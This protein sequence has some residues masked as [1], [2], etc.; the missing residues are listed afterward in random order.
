M[1]LLYIYL[2]PPRL[3]RATDSG[4][5]W[6]TN[7]GYAVMLPSPAVCYR[8]LPFCLYILVWFV[9]SS[10]EVVCATICMRT[11]YVYIRISYSTA[12]RAPKHGSQRQR[13][14]NGTGEG[15]Q[16]QNGPQSCCCK[17]CKNRHGGL[18]WCCVYTVTYIK[19]GA[20][21]WTVAIVYG[22][23]HPYGLWPEISQY[24]I[25]IRERWKR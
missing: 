13:T 20:V 17:D 22:G 15:I 24:V 7:D 21:C 3:H 2:A 9:G 11:V 18:L 1:L 8:C 12:S 14:N 4:F 16:R 19:H 23:G 5:M 10:L 6:P 25:R